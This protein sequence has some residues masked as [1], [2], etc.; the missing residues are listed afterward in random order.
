VVF[1]LGEAMRRLGSILLGLAA[2]LTVAAGVILH[3]CRDNPAPTSPE[4]ASTKTGRT[5]TVTGAGTGGGHVTAPP[6]FEDPRPIELS[7]A[8]V[9]LLC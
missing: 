6:V 7:P 3:G 5:L 4:F 2:T 8:I 9:W 1:T